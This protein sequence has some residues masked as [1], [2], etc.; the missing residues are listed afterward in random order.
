MQRTLYL[1]LL[2]LLLATSAQA[3]LWSW[4]YELIHP[5][6]P[7]ETHECPHHHPHHDTKTDATPTTTT[8]YTD[9]YV[10]ISNDIST[11]SGSDG[12]T[13]TTN[14]GYKTEST[15]QA[16]YWMYVMV[17]GAAVGSVVGAV[18]LSRKR[19]DDSKPKGL[20]NSRMQS[21]RYFLENSKAGKCLGDCGA[22]EMPASG[23][24]DVDFVRV[25]DKA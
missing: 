24:S 7:D 8:T 11:S 25:N 1:S 6:H 5:C 10:D 13:T 9:D 17:A 14:S 4:L 19:M 12:V 3:S 15:H 21:F 20:L 2:T 18:L 23:E 22:I 16:G